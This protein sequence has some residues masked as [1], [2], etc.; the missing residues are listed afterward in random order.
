MEITV[1]KKILTV[2]VD[3]LLAALTAEAA[4]AS[5][6]H[7]IRTKDR[8]VASKQLWNSNAYAAPSDIAVQSDCSEYANGAMASGIAAH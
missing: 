7:H 4:P 1:R 5:E 8:T 3:P 2:L 6:H